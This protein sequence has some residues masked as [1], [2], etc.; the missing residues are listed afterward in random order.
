MG[1]I[2]FENQHQNKKALSLAFHIYKHKAKYKHDFI[3]NQNRNKKEP[4]LAFCIYK[5][6]D[7]YEHDFYR[8][9]KPK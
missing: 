3:E 9:P 8:K 1:E 4:S 7:K 5:H 6:K 2:F